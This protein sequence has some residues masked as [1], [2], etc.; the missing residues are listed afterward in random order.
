MHSDKPQPSTESSKT[1]KPFLTPFLFAL[2][3]AG[4]ACCLSPV[5]LIFIWLTKRLTRRQKWIATGVSVVSLIFWIKIADNP[6]MPSDISSYESA[7]AK[8]SPS[9]P[10][11]PRSS[12]SP[13]GSSVAARPIG[14]QGTTKR[15]FSEEELKSE[16]LQTVKANDGVKIME[17]QLIPQIDSKRANLIITF[18]ASMGWEAKTL[19]DYEMANTYRSLLKPGLPIGDITLIGKATM[20]DAYGNESDDVSIRRNSPVR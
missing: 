7:V 12:V 20:V 6:P 11:T 15:R 3:I 4:S 14:K 19:N 8:V 1:R 16:I 5:G 9:E 10:T 17:V 18:K 13:S 2:F